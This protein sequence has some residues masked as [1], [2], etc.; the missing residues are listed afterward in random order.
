VESGKITHA[1]SWLQEKNLLKKEKIAEGM[2]KVHIKATE[3][4]NNNPE[5]AAAI[6]AKYSG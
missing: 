5:D 6:A 4:I 1:V 2:A 3:Y